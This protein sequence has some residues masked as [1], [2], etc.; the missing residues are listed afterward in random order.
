MAFD[1]R[2]NVVNLTLSADLTTFAAALARIEADLQTQGRQMTTAAEVAAAAK[3]QID[4][5][6]AKVDEVA[7][8]LGEIKAAL[9]AAIVANDLSAIVEQVNRLGVVAEKLKAAEDAA[10]I[11]PDA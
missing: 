7:V 4:A 9:D 10:D 11:T 8:T 3:D 2:A 6:D 5:L 1:L